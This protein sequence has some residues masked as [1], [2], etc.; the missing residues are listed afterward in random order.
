MLKRFWWQVSWRAPHLRKSTTLIGE[1]PVGGA[2]EDYF[3]WGPATLIYY[4]EK[5]NPEAIQPGLYAAVLNSNA[6]SKILT[7]E[8]Q[9]Y[10]NRK[11]I[12]TYPNYRNILILT[13]PT[14]NSCVHVIDGSQP[15]YSRDERDSI[16][17]IGPHSEIEHVLIDEPPHTPPMVVFGPEPPHEWCYYYEK[18]DLARQRGDWEEVLNLG[19]QA[20]NKGFAP[21]DDIEWIPFLQAYAVAGDVHL[22][23]ELASAITVDPYISLQACQR[24]GSMQGL[25]DSV[26]KVVDS[27]YCLE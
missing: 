19:T 27:L 6:V 22:L 2:E 14:L 11:N 23:T 21:Q 13:Q 9:Q 24:I 20:L 18:A 3:V 17:V 26:I 7:R 8:R 5:Q 16:R 12:V 1:Y 15:E 4:P 25:S 10:D